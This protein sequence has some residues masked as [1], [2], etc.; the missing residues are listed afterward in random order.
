MSRFAAGGAGRAR[1]LPRGL[2]LLA[3]VVPAGCSSY[4]EAVPGCDSTRRLALLAQAVPG[5]AYVPCLEEVPEGW[6]AGGFDVG[7]GH[8]RFT[9][10]SD[11]AT[12][13][14]VQVELVGE[15]AA[16]GAVPAPPRAE[17][18]RTAIDLTSI[19]PRFTGT[20]IDVFAGG[21]IRYRFDFP[22]GPHI[23]LME[24]LQASVGLVA[25]RELRLEI[26]K[27]LGVD[28]GP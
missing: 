12:S 21:C 1:R 22:R 3:L 2:L 5:A 14:P 26:E 16:A 7:R 10:R 17:G 19:G 4:T 27:D 28:L 11:R 20:L 18:V 15:C 8:A 9:L 23:G 24:D 13:R 25:R 6:S